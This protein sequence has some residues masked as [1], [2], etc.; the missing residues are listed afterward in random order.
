MKLRSKTWLTLT[1]L[2][3][4]LGGCAQSHLRIEQGFGEALTQDLA[5][6]I[7]DPDAARNAG[8]APPTNGARIGLAMERYQK[9]TVIQP[10]TMGASGNSSGYGSGNGS[11]GGGG[12]GGQTGSSGS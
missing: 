1:V 2:A 10:T 8:P 4:A 5:A 9:G 6:Q 3:A 11:G 12:G 7:A